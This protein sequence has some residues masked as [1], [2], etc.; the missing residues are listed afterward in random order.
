MFII[1][2]GVSALAGFLAFVVALFACCV[3]AVSL[4]GAGCS[5]ALVCLC[6]SW[7]LVKTIERG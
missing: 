1:M 4:V 6:V 2:M 7:V 3:G 5:C